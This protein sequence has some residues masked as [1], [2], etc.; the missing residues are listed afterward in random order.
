[1]EDYLSYPIITGTDVTYSQS[2]DFP[3]VTICN[4]NRINCHNAFQVVFAIAL[5]KYFHS[6]AA[7]EFGNKLA[8]STELSNDERTEL[9]E[10]MDIIN[11]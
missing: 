7:Y 10:I 8:T 11:K 6:Q 4:L 9:V 2:V 3:S 1:M 5:L